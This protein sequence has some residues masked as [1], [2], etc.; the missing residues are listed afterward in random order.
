MKFQVLFQGNKGVS[1]DKKGVVP[2]NFLGLRPQTPSYPLLSISQILGW[3][4][5]W[6]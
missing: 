6:Y 4:R 1:H 3:I 2:K 5:S